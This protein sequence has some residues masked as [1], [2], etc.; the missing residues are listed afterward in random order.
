MLWPFVTL[1]LAL[2]SGVAAAAP[3]EGGRGE[4]PLLPLLALFVVLDMISR[5]DGGCLLAGYKDIYAGQDVGYY[6]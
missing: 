1:A 4:K 6:S 3:D 5:R 2:I